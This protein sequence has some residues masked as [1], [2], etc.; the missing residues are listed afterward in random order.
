MTYATANKQQAKCQ[1]QHRERNHQRRVL[2]ASL[3]SLSQGWNTGK[4][5][6][7][8]RGT[9]SFAGRWSKL[10]CYVWERMHSQR[11]DLSPKQT[12][13]AYEEPPREEALKGGS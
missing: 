5:A 13:V 8:S 9:G 4:G 11:Y 6:L 3:T 10:T 2:L 12:V 1:R 7:K